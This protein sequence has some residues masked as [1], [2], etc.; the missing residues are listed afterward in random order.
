MWGKIEN[1]TA[2]MSV[3]GVS[4]VDEVFSTDSEDS[5]ASGETPSCEY[6]CR[7]CE[8]GGEVTRE[9][10]CECGQET[11]IDEMLSLRVSKH[12][13]IHWC[14]WCANRQLMPSDF[15]IVRTLKQRTN[16]V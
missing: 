4:Q 14:V 5:S 9:I 16:N 12:G 15:A 11:H 3:Y 13:L 6:V 1:A 8:G 10:C 7:V 2:E